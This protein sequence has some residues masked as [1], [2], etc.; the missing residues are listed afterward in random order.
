VVQLIFLNLNRSM[1]SRKRNPSILKSTTEYFEDI[2]P[3]SLEDL[4]KD[5]LLFPSDHPHCE[6]EYLDLPI[7]VDA[8]ERPR[9]PVVNRNDRLNDSSI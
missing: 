9:A 4:D 7:K 8:D 5:G 1:S 6:P 3:P 2:K